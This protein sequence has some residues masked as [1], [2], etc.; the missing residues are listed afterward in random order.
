MSKRK[1]ATV[2]PRIKLHVSIATLSGV[3]YDDLRNIITQAALYN[4]SAIKNARGEIDITYYKKQLRVLDRL[5]AAMDVAIVATL[6]KSAAPSRQDRFEIIRK[7]R[8][9]RILIDQILSDVA[10]EKG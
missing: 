8:R 3:Y 1:Y 7:E 10:K 9:T 4:Y 6:P 5:K 2:N